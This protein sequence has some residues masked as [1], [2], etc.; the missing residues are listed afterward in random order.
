MASSISPCLRF[1]SSGL[2][3]LKSLYN[4]LPYIL[5]LSVLTLLFGRSTLPDL[6][7]FTMASSED[8]NGNTGSIENPSVTKEG[9]VAKAKDILGMEG[10]GQVAADTDD[11]A[12]GVTVDTALL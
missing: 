7:F 3:Y 11:L 1:S 5:Y 6:K 12:V 8:G 10:G 2:Y 4:L 9:K